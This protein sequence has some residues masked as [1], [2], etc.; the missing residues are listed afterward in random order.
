MSDKQRNAL[1]QAQAW[2]ERQ[3]AIASGQADDIPDEDYADMFNAVMALIEDALEE[4]TGWQPIETAPKDG[5]WFLICR[6]GDADSVE[7]GRYRPYFVPEFVEVEGGLY[8]KESKSVS[9]WDGFNN[10]HRA[11]HWCSFEPLTPTPKAEG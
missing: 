5:T 1:L 6:K 7:V 2:L 10:I 4:P 9:D 8:R 11:T 3:V